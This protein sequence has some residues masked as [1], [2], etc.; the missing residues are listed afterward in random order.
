MAML[1]S[2]Y[3]GYFNYY[4]VIGNSKG[5]SE[6]YG[7]SLKILYKW[8]NRRSQRKGF[9]W[10]EFNKKMNWYGLIKPRVVERAETQMRIEICFE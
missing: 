2:K 7:P 3:R 4:G 6:F 10:E 9:N 1:N 5:L 8:M